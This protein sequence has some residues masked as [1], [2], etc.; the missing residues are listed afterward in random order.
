MSAQYFGLLVVQREKKEKVQDVIDFAIQMLEVRSFRQLSKGVKSNIE[1]ILGFRN[2]TLFFKNTG[3]D[4]LFTVANNELTNPFKRDDPDYIDTTFAKEL[5]F[6]PDQVVVFPTEMG[7]TGECH[8]R[9]TFHYD[10]DFGQLVQKGKLDKTTDDFEDVS[11]RSAKSNPKFS[12][13]RHSQ[14]HV[15]AFN[16]NLPSLN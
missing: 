8:K 5:V 1:G 9:R 2:C 11:E 12:T 16:L 13:S 15:P 4:Q 14:V 6:P 7:V 10:N 3:T